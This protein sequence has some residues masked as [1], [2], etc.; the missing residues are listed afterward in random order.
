MKKILIKSFIQ[1]IP[2]VII[3]GILAILA[4]YT[5]NAFLQT[6]SDYSFMVVPSLLAGFIAKEKCGSIGFIPAIILGT[7][8]QPLNLGM[9]GGVLSGIIISFLVEMLKKIKISLE[10]SS[11]MYLVII[12]VTSTL[13]GGV[14]MYYILLPPLT[15]AME[16]INV[17][18]KTLNNENTIFLLFI[19]GGMI[20][21][22]LGGP[23]NKMAFLY[24]VS[25]LS[26]GRYDIM[27]PLAVAICI[28]PLSLGI[29]QFILRDRFSDVE[30]EAGVLSILLGVLG[31]TEGALVYLTKDIKVLPVTVISSAIGACS[32]TILHVT[33]KAPHGGLITLPLVEN[34]VEFIISV[35]IGIVSAIF[36]LYFLKPK[37]EEER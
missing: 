11:I 3:G 12:P 33:S 21:V 19:L 17:Y 32:A 10:V 34:R 18:L 15:F 4:L 14:F 6:L 35:L 13:I 27:G 22:D 30:R 25:T 37:I 16:Y 23:I 8:S 36:F 9:I 1:V 26:H 24:G 31:I 29:A 7:L 20:G 5:S 2:A 28:P